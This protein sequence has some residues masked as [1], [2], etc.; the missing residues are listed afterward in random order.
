M[1]MYN[2][3]MLV[4]APVRHG[5]YDIVGG[6][7]G[8]WQGFSMEEARLHSEAGAAAA[9]AKSPKE[10]LWDLQKG[11]TRFWMGVASR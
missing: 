4:R 5:G 10:V 11:N 1:H 6:M 7:D 2:T 9:A 3:S 8:E